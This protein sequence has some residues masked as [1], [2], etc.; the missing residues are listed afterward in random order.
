MTDSIEKINEAVDKRMNE[1]MKII[2][3]GAVIYRKEIIEV[4][5]SCINNYVEEKSKGETKIQNE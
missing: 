2:N 1:R 3:E 4:V 5:D